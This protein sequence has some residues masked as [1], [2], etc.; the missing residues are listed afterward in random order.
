[1]SV[2][3]LSD[4]LISDLVAARSVI[5]SSREVKVVCFF[6]VLIDNLNWALFGFIDRM[7][8]FGVVTSLDLVFILY[9]VL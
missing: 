1:M 4:W 8:L 3:F 5:M 2:F 6:V 9:Q 7:V